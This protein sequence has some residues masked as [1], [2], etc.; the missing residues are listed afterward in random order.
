MYTFKVPKMSC[1][2]CV[3][4]ITNAIKHADESA[5]VDANVATKTVKVD[6][7]LTEVELTDILSNIGYPAV[8]Q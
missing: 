5:T 3:N 2:G 1:G 6:S 4:T 7:S 8:Y